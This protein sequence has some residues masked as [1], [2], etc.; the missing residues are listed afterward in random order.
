MK[1]IAKA[2]LVDRKDVAQMLQA[3]TGRV[4]CANAYHSKIAERNEIRASIIAYKKRSPQIL[5]IYQLYSMKN[6]KHA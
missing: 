1:G 3:F 4:I 6:S 2:S 5:N